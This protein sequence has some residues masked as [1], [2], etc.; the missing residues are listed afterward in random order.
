MSAHATPAE[1]PKISD[2]VAG[3]YG[4][5]T[6]GYP[7][8]DVVVGDG[9]EY[10]R[11]RGMAAAQKLIHDELMWRMRRHRRRVDVGVDDAGRPY[12]GWTAYGQL[13]PVCPRRWEDRDLDL[14]PAVPNWAGPHNWAAF[15]WAAL[16]SSERFTGNRE[17]L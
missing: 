14:G 11:G 2:Y 8:L 16:N 15:H 4:L 17:M 3:Y 13:L 7:G 5:D 1:L 6:A 12:L 10:L 9:D